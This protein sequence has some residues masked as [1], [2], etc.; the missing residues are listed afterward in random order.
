MDHSLAATQD[1]VSQTLVAVLL[2]GV[3]GLLVFEKAHRVLITLSAVA[4][5]WLITYLTPF[6]LIS[7]EASHRAIDLNVLLLL[8]AMMAVVGVLKTTGVFG[9]AVGRLIARSG[10]D[11]TLLLTM[12]IWF[13]GVLSALCDNVTTVIFVFPM[14]LEVARA[15]RLKPAALLLPMVIASNIGGT[16]TLI[17]D[18]PNILIG[19]G[20]GLSFLDFLE[21]LTV[22]VLWMMVA[23]GIFSRRYFRSALRDSAPADAS[24]IEAGIAN[25]EL[26]R[27]GLAISALIFAGFLTHGLTG[28][29]AAVPAVI[30]AAM[31]LIAQDV[32]HTRKYAVSATERVHGI[33]EIIEGEIEWPTLAFFAFLFITVGAAVETG[34]IDTLARSL[35]AL[36]G[37]AQAGLGLSDRGTLLFAAILILWVSGLLSALIDNIPYVAVA[38]P[39]IARLVTGMTGDT[40]ILWWALA[41][42][43]CLGGNGTLIGASANVTVTGLAER[44]GYGISFREFARFG[45]PIMVIT[46]L[47]ATGF[48]ASHLY[49]GKLPT[50]GAGALGLAAY[51]GVGLVRGRSRR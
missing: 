26:L 35:T 4:L 10:G 37:W 25:P 24:M 43:A 45:S 34:L 30:G 12:L 5:L 8:A 38:I 19:S 11:P 44:A 29:P 18:P 7:F 2:V 40:E 42:G 22:P 16:A 28:M 1:P 20:A 49:V 6:R 39:I 31:I 27:W 50:A 13:T 23:C 41:L 9:W 36:I 14:A 32:Q 33:L 51:A 3:L 46:L 17:G 48:I 21:N 15:C 47:I